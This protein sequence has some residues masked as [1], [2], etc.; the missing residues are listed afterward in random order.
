MT[1]LHYYIFGYCT[2]KYDSF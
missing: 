2:R 1:L